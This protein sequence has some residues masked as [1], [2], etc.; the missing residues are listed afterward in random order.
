M[1]RRLIGWHSPS[2]VPAFCAPVVLTVSMSLAFA[3]AEL[4][5]DE[6]QQRREQARRSGSPAWLWPEVRVD[7]WSAAMAHLSTA[8]S[9]ILAGRRAALPPSEPMVLS[10]ACY[11]SGVGP[12]LGFWLE[13]GQLTAADDANELLALHFEHA[14]RRAKLVEVQSREVATALADCGVPVVVLKGGHTAYSYFPDPATRP[15]SDL[16][17]LVPRDSAAQ[18]EVALAK[19]RLECAAR[20]KHE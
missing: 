12:L 20:S 6:F 13:T 3:T 17:L 1:R 11:T 14:R 10:L 2:K 5:A 9:G 18:A 19:A 4:S 16:D 8:A 15:S 7:D